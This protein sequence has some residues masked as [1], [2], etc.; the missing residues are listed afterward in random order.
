MFSE[1]PDDPL[2][3]SAAGAALGVF[4]KLLLLKRAARTKVSITDGSA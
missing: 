3:V 4:I 2:D 1:E